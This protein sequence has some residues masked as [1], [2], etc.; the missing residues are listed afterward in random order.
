MVNFVKYYPAILKKNKSGHYIEYYV[1]N[2]DTGKLVRKRIKLNR[3]KNAR[4]RKQIATEIIKDLNAKLAEGW[5][6]F[7]EQEAPNGFSTIQHAFQKYLEIKTK[8]LR[9]ETLRSLNVYIG[10]WIAWV[11]TRLDKCYVVNITR[12]HVTDYLHYMYVEKGNGEKYVN[13]TLK[14]I[15]SF[16]N[17]LKDNG[18]ISVNITTGIKKLKE[19]PKKRQIIPDDTLQLIFSHLQHTNP[20]Y[21]FICYLT[22]YTMLRPKEITRLRI[23]DLHIDDGVVEV[24]PESSKVGKLRKLTMPRRMQQLARTLGLHAYDPDMYII[25]NLRYEPGTTQLDSRYI[26]KTWA[27]LRNTLGLPAKY[28]FYSLKDT[29]IVKMLRSGISP[30][31][32]RD[33]AGHSSLEMT[34]RYIILAHNKADDEIANLDY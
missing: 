6:P 22:Y 12:K 25:S 34:N 2:P 17:W 20:R 32:V 1:T 5:N 26:A 4:Q 8:E 24:P 33:Q 27:K 23:R 9:P 10:K 18:Y 30:D 28:Q 14:F 19:Q 16:Y 3:I 29:G 31:K 15:S 7:I 11:C 13:N 21:L